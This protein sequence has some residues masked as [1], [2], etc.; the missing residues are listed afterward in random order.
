MIR[1]LA[2]AT[3]ALERID[4]QLPAQQ[5]ALIRGWRTGTLLIKN[6][7]FHS[8]ELQALQRFCQE[9]SFDTA[10]YPQMPELKANRY[11]QLAEPIYF[12]AAQAILSDKR[13]QF[14]QQYP[15]DIRP[16]TDNR[17]YFFQFLR[18]GSLVQMM[19]TIGRNAIPFVEWGYLL[20]IATLIQAS[21]AGLIL[22]LVPL[23]FLRRQLKDVRQGGS[24]FIF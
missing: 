14:Y 16:V 1:L 3:E 9:R 4:R 11:N 10:Y 5:L 24:S 18:L 6:G 19:R 22:I 12:R 21:L 15:F 20:L 13:T 17:P 8:Q 7:R 23:F 2:I